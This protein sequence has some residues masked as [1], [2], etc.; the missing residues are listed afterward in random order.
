MGLREVFDDIL[1][2]YLLEIQQG[3][4]NKQH[5]MFKVINYQS[6]EV[7]EEIIGNQMLKVKGS[8]GAGQWTRYPWIAIYNEEVTTTIQEGVYI[9]YLFSED[10]SR[11]YLTLNQGC[12]NLKN[13]LGTKAAKEKMKEVRETI[14]LH[15]QQNSF[16]EDNNLEIGNIDYEVGSIFYKVYEQ[17]HL[18]NEEIL[19]SDLKKL[20]ALYERY[21]HEIYEEQNHKKALVQ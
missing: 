15:M 20:I 21:Y 9:V 6:K 5:R 3:K 17:H 19:Q 10:M 8:C 14:R 12:T 16:N 1:K 13:K 11:L 18:P 2:N 4:F 7:L